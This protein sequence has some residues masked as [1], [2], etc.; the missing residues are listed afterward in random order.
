MEMKKRYVIFGLFMMI[1]CLISREA[2]AFS[3][4]F[5][6]ANN[7]YRQGQYQQA[8]EQYEQILDNGQASGALYYNLGN[9]Y[10]KTGQLGLA[11]L[12]YE[13][14]KQYIP[15]DSDLRANYAFAL[16]QVKRTSSTQSPSFIKK[17]W[18]S[19]QQQF[20]LDRLA[21]IIFALYAGGL[22]VLAV[23]I[24]SGRSA[25]LLRIGLGLIAVLLVLHITTF[26]FKK[27]L[28][29]RAAVMTQPAD[30]L[31]EPQIKATKHFTL[32]EGTRVQIL[33]Q[34]DDWI[35]VQRLDG[36]MGWSPASAVTKI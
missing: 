2:S 14:A 19:Y 23:Y 15:Q 8:I 28:E 6:E 12:N 1:L 29:A 16:S 25:V 32:F 24:C 7:H 5:E 21:K 18:Q 35:K 20:S 10:F 13:R 4:L 11:V 30:A 9:S 27:N 34:R 33:E 3:K 36:K 22:F 26:Y 31:F 17:T